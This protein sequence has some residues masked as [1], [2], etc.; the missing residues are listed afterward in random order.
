M[1]LLSIIANKVGI[2]TSKGVRIEAKN[3]T[4]FD[5]TD[6]DRT[7]TVS[8]N[9][10]T[11]DATLE[12][13]HSSSVDI[14]DFPIEDGSIISDH[15]ILKPKELTI[16]GIITD[17]PINPLAQLTGLIS[18]GAVAASAK[19]GVP[20]IGGVLGAGL[21]ASI[22]G[23]LG[24]SKNR[25]K[26]A[27]HFLL[28]LQEQRQLFDVVTGLKLYKNMCLTSLSVPRRTDTGQAIRFSASMREIKI[29]SSEII[30]IPE[31]VIKPFAAPSGTK[32]ADL[33]RQT[34]QAMT[35]QKDEKY[36][37]ILRRIFQ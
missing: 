14:T 11:I 26:D 32:K 20:I 15:F 16:E 1:S 25:A 33:A 10:L 21:G 17:T 3:L 37:S 5:V 18:V 7:R 35:A 23:L 6:E 28:E 22:G 4:K 36:T 8:I 9:V 30:S 12:E 34:K 27:F 31:A 29:V 19:L 2:S 13:S 24:V